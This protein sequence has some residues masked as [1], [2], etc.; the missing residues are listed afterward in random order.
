VLADDRSAAGP[1]LQQH[2]P[3]YPTVVAEH[4]DELCA[5][6]GAQAGAILSFERG[7]HVHVE[8]RS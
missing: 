5:E 7:L 1:W 3:D 8:Q 4:F 6:I 2:L